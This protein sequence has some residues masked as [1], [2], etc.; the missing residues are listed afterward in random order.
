VDGSAMWR[1]TSG[2]GNL[3]APSVSPLGNL[4]VVTGGSTMY[5][6][7]IRGSLLWSVTT[8][9]GIYGP[10]TFASSSAMVFVLSSTLLSAVQA[11]TGQVIWTTNSGI[12]SY[13]GYS[14]IAVGPDGT[15]YTNV[16]P[17]VAA[18]N[19]TNGAMLWQ[20]NWPC[21]Q[22]QAGGDNVDGSIAIGIDST[23]FAAFTCA[24]PSGASLIAFTGVPIT[25]SPSSP[26]KPSNGDKLNLAI[27]LTFGSLAVLGLAVWVWR[28]NRKGQQAMATPLI[29]TT[30]N[31]S[32]SANKSVG[33]RGLDW[34]ASR[35]PLQK[36]TPLLHQRDAHLGTL[37]T[38]L[39]SSPA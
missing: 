18:Y 15:V 5:A 10:V 25:V 23:V 19:P 16:F 37:R 3:S 34:V 28:R 32:T 8:T 21:T 6:F 29:A 1:Y 33:I 22:P 31:Q 38:H 4:I 13:G 36:K 2:N 39:L 35:L 7:N 11:T 30:S 26:S 27:G 9:D 14:S 12:G 20:H 17:N 24:S